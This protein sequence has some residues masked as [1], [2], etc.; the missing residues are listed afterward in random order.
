MHARKGKNDEEKEI[1]NLKTY[2]I[3][4]QGDTQALRCNIL[5]VLSMRKLWIATQDC[6]YRRQVREH[7]YHGDFGIS[8]LISLCLNHWDVNSKYD[9]PA[10]PC[11]S[12]RKLM[13]VGTL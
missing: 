11:R 6:E 5:Q 13:F 10:S 12:G 9:L 7:I 8:G 3:L 2:I 4:G 1:Y